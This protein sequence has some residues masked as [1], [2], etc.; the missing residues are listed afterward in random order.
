MTE[1]TVYGSRAE[2]LEGRRGGL[3]ASDC[4]VVLGV[5]NFKTPLQLW[6]EKIGAVET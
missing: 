1:R 3:G 2:W 6:R 5:S 4:G